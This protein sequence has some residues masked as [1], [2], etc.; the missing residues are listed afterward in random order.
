MNRKHLALPAL[1]LSLLA[2]SAQAQVLPEATLGIKIPLIV[3]PSTR[4]MT[5]VYVPEYQ[6]YYIADGGLGPVPGDMENMTSKSAVHVYDS[7]GKYLQ[8]ALPGYNNR[9]MYYNPT[10][11]QLETV[12]Y[13]ISSDAGFAPDTG[14]FALELQENGDLKTTSKDVSGYNPAFGDAATMPSYNYDAKVYYAKQEHS[15]KVFVVELT[16]REKVGEIT[17]DLKAAGANTDDVHEHYIAYTGVKGEEL[18][19]LDI[20]HKAVLVF[21]TEGKFVGK[22]ALPKTLK[23]RAQNHYTGTGYTRGMLFIMSEPEGEFGTYYGFKFLELA[24]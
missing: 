11:Y 24:Q 23:L 17:L 10:T 12:T 19:I 9:S 14:I 21:D 13:N 4:P 5:V 15:N 8:T 1:L 2:L 7:E 16:K 6:R 3:K 20:D 22:S 18:A